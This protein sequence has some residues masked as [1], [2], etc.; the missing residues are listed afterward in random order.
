MI[1]LRLDNNIAS[2]P[3]LPWTSKTDNYHQVVIKY[4]AL[5]HN[6][7]TIRVC[8][9]CLNDYNCVFSCTHV[10]PF[11]LQMELLWWNT[12]SDLI[13]KVSIN[14]IILYIVHVCPYRCKYCQRRATR[15][16][17][18]FVRIP[19]AF[20]CDQIAPEPPWG[21]TYSAVTLSPESKAEK[22]RKNTL[23]IQSF[24]NLIQTA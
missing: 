3:I 5:F 15:T 7:C 24:K 13:W 14:I 8:M 10:W 17:E 12:N 20:G 9:N 1:I 6:K 18:N 2:D 11:Y 19:R 23:G 16:S 21:W 4:G 22:Q